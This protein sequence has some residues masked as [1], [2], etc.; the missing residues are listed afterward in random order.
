MSWVSGVSPYRPPVWVTRS[1]HT[2]EATRAR[3]QSAR[4]QAGN[5]AAHG[6][7]IFLLPRA[8][9]TGAGGRPDRGAT[10]VWRGGALVHSPLGR[11]E[12]QTLRGQK[13]WRQSMATD[14]WN[15]NTRHHFHSGQRALPGITIQLC[16]H[17]DVVLFFGLKSLNHANLF[18]TRPPTRPTS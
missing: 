16:N 2:V 4:R 11:R 18:L 14:S 7:H 3:N 10:G 8:L 15:K 17:G 6:M 9:V 5:R 12:N 13:K 1:Q